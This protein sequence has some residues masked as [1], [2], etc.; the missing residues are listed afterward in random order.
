MSPSMRDPSGRL[1]IA[2]VCAALVA[3]VG[4]QVWQSAHIHMMIPLEFSWRGVLDGMPH[5][6][7]FQNRILGPLML[8]G[9]GAMGLGGL[10]NYVTLWLLAGFCV[11]GAF[12]VRRHG[13]PAL[14]VGLLVGLALWCLP[15]HDLSYAWDLPEMLFLLAMSIMVIKQAGPAPFFVLYAVALLNRES[16]LIVCFYLGMRAL[17]TGD[18]KLLLG[19]TVAAVL[20]WAFVHTLRE[21]LFRESALPNVGLDESNRLLGNHFNLIKNLVILRDAPLGPMQHRALFGYAL[22][23][24][25]H[26]V[27]VWLFWRRGQRELTWLSATLLAYLAS[28][29]VL[30]SIFEGR[31]YQPFALSTGVLLCELIWGRSSR[32]GA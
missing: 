25:G 19:A 21:T 31:I 18:R 27:A 24:A 12:L 14:G 13:L 9:M 16:A 32:S 29:V 1:G 4:S 11:L 28:M 20:G 5:W 2:L 26:A 3:W 17:A 6:R 30:G 8:Q 7:A 15:M 10:S 22:L 23:L